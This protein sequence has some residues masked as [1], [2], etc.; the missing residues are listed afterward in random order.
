MLNCC[1]SSHPEPPHPKYRVPS[2][3]PPG[4]GHLDPHAV[5]CRL[6][7][8][9]V[10]TCAVPNL[11]A[12]DVRTALARA[13]SVPVHHL[14]KFSLVWDGVGES[15]MQVWDEG[16]LLP[17]ETFF[18]WG[19]GRPNFHDGTGHRRRVTARRPTLALRR[20]HAPSSSPASS[21][22]I[23]RSCGDTASSSC[24]GASS[25]DAEASSD[26]AAYGVLLLESEQ[27]LEE[28]AHG[29]Y[30]AALLCGHA[31]TT[32]RDD[33]RGDDDTWLDACALA[34]VVRLG[35]HDPS[36][37][38]S[39]LVADLVAGI[40]PAMAPLL[41]G[42]VDDLLGRYR[43]WTLALSHREGAEE[44]AEEPQGAT[45]SISS[46][47]ARA[48]LVACVRGALPVLSTA[49]ADGARPTLTV[50]AANAAEAA[51][52][53]DEDAVR[54]DLCECA[55]FG[56]VRLDQPTN[57]SRARLPRLLMPRMWWPDEDEYVVAI[58]AAGIILYP[59][60]LT[61]A[62]HPPE[63][64]ALRGVPPAALLLP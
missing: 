14:E 44:G 46:R 59:C 51:G 38:S 52:T 64:E 1:C 12:S 19:S 22:S 41:R 37:H 18:A 57:A 11:S 47:N 53:G 29:A 25:G 61:T 31:E 10:C 2:V 56:G 50:L 54:V 34:M 42:R 16:M 58:G 20:L 30:P 48:E 62:A 8:G 3:A 36:I 7:G 17:P 6:P 55:I 45:N 24:D 23:G 4:H 27:V 49:S 21:S 28:L 35:A 43:A 39:Q 26:G 40:L 33:A 9:R 63:R 15:G 32:P 60:V 13:L 5:S